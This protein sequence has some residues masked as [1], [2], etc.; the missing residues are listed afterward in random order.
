MKD[1]TLFD[2]PANGPISAFT[3]K[4]VA[5]AR[6]TD[7]TESHE[8]A[9]RVD[10]TA[11]QKLVLRAARLGAGR[12]DELRDRIS[13]NG[14]KISPS[15]CRTRCREL[16]DARLLYVVNHIQKHAVYAL[17][18]EGRVVADRIAREAHAQERT[19]A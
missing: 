15:G 19:A 6:S 2:A 18:D 1:A 13:A 14:C 4:P 8:A 5:K 11:S 3:G 12:A 9:S 16:T 10:V 17:T 7:P